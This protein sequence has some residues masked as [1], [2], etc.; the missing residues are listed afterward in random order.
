M[1]VRYLPVIFVLA[2]LVLALAPLETAG[3][4]ASGAQA[5]PSQPAHKADD[6]PRPKTGGAP[7]NAGADQKAV[8][9]DTDVR[10]VRP[11]QAFPPERIAPS[12]DPTPQAPSRGGIQTPDRPQTAPAPARPPRDDPRSVEEQSDPGG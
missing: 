9:P 5:D 10:Q 8:P 3:Q 4:P 12:Q 7:V 11:A 6:K 2:A 1:L